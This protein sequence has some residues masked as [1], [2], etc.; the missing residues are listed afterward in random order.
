MPRAVGHKARFFLGASLRVFAV[1][2]ALTLSGIIGILWHE[3]VG[4]GLTCIL[5]GGTITFVEVLGL[6]VYPDVTWIGW[7]FGFHFGMCGNDGLMD[8]TS[9]AVVRLGGS[10]STW[11]VAVFATVMLLRRRKRGILTW[12][13]ALLSIWWLDAVL[14]T[15]P[16]WGLRK[17]VFWGS[18][19]AEPYLAA[20]DLG[21]PGWLF[22]VI[23]FG[24][25]FVMLFCS[26]VKLATLKRMPAVPRNSA[27]Q[28]DGFTDD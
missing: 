15:L 16:V 5:C 6:R 25:A 23:V 27:E 28:H 8:F 11:L 9:D 17:L 2:A 22:Q 4:H 14:Y 3:V 1:A 21:C 18:N 10:L 24:S 7:P 13:L 20:T 12:G 19:Y 26:I